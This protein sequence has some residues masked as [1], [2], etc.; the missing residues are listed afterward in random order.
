MFGKEF[1]LIRRFRSLDSLGPPGGGGGRLLHRLLLGNQRLLGFRILR[2]VLRRLAGGVQG[3]LFF[4]RRLLPFA[5]G[6]SC[7][8]GSHVGEGGGRGGGVGDGIGDFEIWKGVER[9]VGETFGEREGEG[10]DGVDSST[11]FLGF[12]LCF[13]FT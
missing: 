1:G 13:V 10:W 6:G 9:T 12:L 4:L 5:F 11:V 7:S 8:S 2:L 3:Q